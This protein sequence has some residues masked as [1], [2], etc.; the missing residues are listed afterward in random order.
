MSQ[1]G[2]VIRFIQSYDLRISN[3]G[4]RPMKIIFFEYMQQPRFWIAR[5]DDGYWLVP[6]KDQGWHERSPFVGRVSHLNVLSDF[7]GIDLGLPD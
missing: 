3:I 2:V 6:V 1:N 4:R 7:D 5:D